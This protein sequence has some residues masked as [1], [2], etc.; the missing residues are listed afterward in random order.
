[1]YDTVNFW[2]DRTIV[3]DNIFSIAQYLSDVTESYNEKI[4]RQITGFIGN[5][6]VTINGAG[7]RLTGSLSRFY[8]GTNVLSLTR[9]TAYQAILCLSNKIHLPI[10]KAKVTR[11]DI[12]AVFILQMPIQMYLSKLGNKPYFDRILKTNGS[13][14]YDTN[15]KQLTFYDKSAE[16]KA[17]KRKI[18]PNY[19][20]KNLMR[21]E[22][23]FSKNICNQLKISEI[24]GE[25]LT[26]KEFY[27]SLVKTWAAEY[28]SITKLKSMSLDNISD[29]KTPKDVLNRLLA[30]QLNQMGIDEINKMFKALK[31]N[32]NF[33]DPKS[34]T[35]L[36]NS[37]FREMNFSSGNNQNNLIVELNNEVNKI[38][39][40]AIKE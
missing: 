21:Y 24:T 16:Q 20:N 29:L 23:K 4:G 33:S 32:H 30:I 40:L 26:N 28:H 15:K 37:L 27:S 35:R 8:L 13:L 25:T 22:L 10:L 3:G 17:K 5:Y 36:K 14:S 34:H 12:S 1:M 38:L 31:A 11:I 19:I 18:P 7:V 2:L 9:E 6:R 39:Q